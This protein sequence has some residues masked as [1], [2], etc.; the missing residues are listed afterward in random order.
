MTSKSSFG[1]TGWLVLRV[2]CQRNGFSQL[3]SWLAESLKVCQVCL[4]SKPGAEA[5]LEN[6][7]SWPSDFA[8]R[9]P[10]GGKCSEYPY[11]PCRQ[12]KLDPSLHFQE[13]AR[14]AQ[15]PNWGASRKG[16]ERSLL[17]DLFFFCPDC[18]ELFCGACAGGKNSL[19]N[20][21]SIDRYRRAGCGAR[22]NW[23]YPPLK[24]QV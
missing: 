18:W 10:P 21:V 9:P 13:H 14:R 22:T 16:L 24:L 15:L 4:R 8:A 20:H 3:E 1:M 7:K 2:T 17:L 5:N 11:F 6:I 23:S 19:R 12:I